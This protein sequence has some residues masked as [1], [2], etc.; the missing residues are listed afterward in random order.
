MNNDA[1]KVY[2]P[3]VGKGGT[4]TV[5]YFPLVTVRKNGNQLKKVLLRDLPGANDINSHALLQVKLPSSEEKKIIL[6][7]R[8]I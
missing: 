8:T 6:F 4:G 1:E 3:V 5:Y 7:T 2:C